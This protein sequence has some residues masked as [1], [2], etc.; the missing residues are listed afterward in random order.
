MQK[1]IQWPYPKETVTEMNSWLGEVLVFFQKYLHLHIF[2]D[3]YLVHDS[4]EGSISYP[5]TILPV[6]I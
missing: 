6:L 2:G 4:Q 1:S 5:R 3:P